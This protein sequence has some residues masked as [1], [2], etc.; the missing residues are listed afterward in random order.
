MLFSCD[1][2]HYRSFPT[3]RSSD[4]VLDVDLGPPENE[5]PDL[6]RLVDEDHAV[7]LRRDDRR[8][9]DRRVAGRRDRKSTRLNSSHITM[10]YAGICLN[11]K[12]DT[13]RARMPPVPG[14][15]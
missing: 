5:P 8:V 6:S 10:S 4:L 3:R 2:G 11:K 1:R 13:V 9:G 12:K 7:G 15:A 14:K